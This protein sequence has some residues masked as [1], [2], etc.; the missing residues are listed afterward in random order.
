M[1]RTRTTDEA[2]H[3]DPALVK[4]LAHPVRMRVLSRLNEIVASPKELAGEFGVSLP[5]ISYHFRVLAELGAIELV[6]ETQRRGAIEHHYRALTRAFFDD[7]DWKKLPVTSR[8]G[9]SGTVVNQALTD[10]T[11]AFGAG[12]F[13]ARDDRHLSYTPL[14][15]DEAG[16]TD[17][18]ELLAET[19]DR[20]L[21][22]QADSAA[23][24]AADGS[25]ETLSARLTIAGYEAAPVR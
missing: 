15:L 21:Q 25:T 17:L 24:L 18:T 13:D 9:V 8:Q 2:A 19:L 22:I 16:W 5:M 6:R 7:A 11:A 23:R 20:A 12:T 4:A 10:L 1:P 14:A 3:L